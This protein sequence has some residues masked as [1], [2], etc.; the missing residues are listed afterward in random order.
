MEPLPKGRQ[1][2]L[3]LPALRRSRRQAAEQLASCLAGLGAAAGACVY[4]C[5]VEPSF[6][7]PGF[8]GERLRESR[9]GR[10]YPADPFFEQADVCGHDGVA[11]LD[12][13]GLLERPHSPIVGASGHLARRE[14]EIRVR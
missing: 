4:E 3:D 1:Q 6:V 8:D 14:P 5:Q 10:F 13:I 7:E 11:W 2:T 12:G 9:D